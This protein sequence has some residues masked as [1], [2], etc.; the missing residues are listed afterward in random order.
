MSLSVWVSFSYLGVVGGQGPIV[1][2]SVH[3]KVHS[4]IKNFDLEASVKC[5]PQHGK[6]SE[7]G[8]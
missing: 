3:V 7:I 2:E 5:Q 4:E 1:S 6:P 8:C